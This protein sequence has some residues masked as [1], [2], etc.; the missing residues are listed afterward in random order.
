MGNSLSLSTTLPP[1]M[2]SRNLGQTVLLER[3]IKNG[4][5][6]RQLTLS[7]PLLPDSQDVV[8]QEGAAGE[9]VEHLAQLPYGRWV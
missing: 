4:E 3:Y 1:R 8:V 2:R 6:G 7:S 5:V 9:D